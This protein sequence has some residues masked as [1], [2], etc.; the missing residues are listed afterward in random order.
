MPCGVGIRAAAHCECELSADC[1]IFGQILVRVSQVLADPRA[2]FLIITYTRHERRRHPK[3]TRANEF[4]YSRRIA[5]VD[6][7][8][9]LY[10]FK[11]SR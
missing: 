10:I 1:I 3:R 8:N 4:V 9:K 11:E 6:T 5:C 7:A 2:A